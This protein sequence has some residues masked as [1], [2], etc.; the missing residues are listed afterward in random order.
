MDGSMKKNFKIILMV[1]S[2]IFILYAS[3]E[4]G[5]K[6]EIYTNNKIRNENL[7]NQIKLDNSANENLSISFSK[8]A[9]D[10]LTK[11]SLQEFIENE[12]MPLGI[13][14]KVATE[15]YHS[16]I[17]FGSRAGEL[18][19]KHLMRT[20][21]LKQT[22]KLIEND[23]LEKR[24]LENLWAG[25]PSS[26]VRSSHQPYPTIFVY[27]S[28]QSD[29]F[30]NKKPEDIDIG[31]DDINWIK[32]DKLAVYCMATPYDLRKAS[33]APKINTEIVS[34][35]VVESLRVDSMKSYYDN[36]NYKKMKQD[37]WK[38]LSN[39]SEYKMAYD[40]VRN[41]NSKIMKKIVGD[42]QPKYFEELRAQKVAS[43]REKAVLFKNP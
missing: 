41:K 37:F 7:S 26:F 10:S 9:A 30:K 1:I 20:L 12:V 32:F 35:E 29:S 33:S 2:F 22:F 8:C 5:Q 43:D 6:Y 40:E 42:N 3:Y 31:I 19:G 25:T 16:R 39:T 23:N 4:V 36:Y 13:A 21:S 17:I 38:K 27:Y 24:H 15:N 11:Q 28:T 14:W 18:L 34:S